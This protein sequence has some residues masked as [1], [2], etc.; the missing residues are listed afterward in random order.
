MGVAVGG[1]LVVIHAQSISYVGEVWVAEARGVKVVVAE[2][3]RTRFT[4]WSSIDVVGSRRGYVRT[5][6]CAGSVGEDWEE[7]VAG[8]V[9]S[10]L[11]RLV[12]G[13]CACAAGVGAVGGAVVGRAFERGDLGVLVLLQDGRECWSWGRFWW[14][15]V[16][17]S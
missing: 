7:V 12:T 16:V 10:G 3:S 8:V 15:A 14:F 9:Q 6:A 5:R 4:P 2:L 11:N 1:R 13:D 17:P